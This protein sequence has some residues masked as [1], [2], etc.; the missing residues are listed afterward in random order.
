MNL[1]SAIGEVAKTLRVIWS[2]SAMLIHDL[3]KR[4]AREK[5]TNSY[6]STVDGLRKRKSSTKPEDSTE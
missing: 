2:D 4:I 3:K 1:L 5:A 6:N